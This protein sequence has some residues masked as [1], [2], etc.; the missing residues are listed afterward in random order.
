MNNYFR[1]RLWGCCILYT[2]WNVITRQSELTFCTRRVKAVFS[3]SWPNWNLL[4]QQFGGKQ[5]PI[6]MCVERDRSPD[7]ETVIIIRLLR[8]DF[9]IVESC[10][11]FRNKFCKF[12]SLLLA[13]HYFHS[14]LI[15][16][17]VFFPIEVFWKFKMC[18]FFSAQI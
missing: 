17:L 4:N 2:W 14:F 12:N 3:P 8:S 6:T 9:F 16:P 18:T 10:R 5:F 1:W 13:H 15:A 11:I 7:I